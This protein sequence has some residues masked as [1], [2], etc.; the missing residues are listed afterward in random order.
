VHEVAEERVLL[1][2]E[3]RPRDE[4]TLP[5]RHPHILRRATEGCTGDGGLVGLSALVNVSA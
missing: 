5:V 1:L 4:G 2:P 3:D